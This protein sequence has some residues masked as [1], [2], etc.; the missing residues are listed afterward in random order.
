M[1]GI[2]QV[3]R[4]GAGRLSLDFI[5]TL[6]RRGTPA[7]EEELPTPA[8]LAAWV[9]QLGPCRTPTTEPPSPRTLARAH[10]LREA[11]TV[12]LHAACSAQGVTGCPA[13]VRE[14]VNLA[15]A[16]GAAPVPVL[17]AAG[18]L[19]WQAADPVAAT[20]TLIARDA[21]EL[22]ASPLAHRLR[23]CRGDE[24]ACLF[25]DNSR[26]GSRRWCSMSSCGNQA[27]KAAFRERER[28]GG[29]A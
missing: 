28:T 11:V 24:C 15:A 4:E 21:L 2:T 14:A 3:F 18:L 8:A 10:E 25:L 13:D 23:E 5:R 9:H 27:K 1:T 22:A 17:D 26:P 19:S 16:E 7:A 20:L 29:G 12:L 6:R